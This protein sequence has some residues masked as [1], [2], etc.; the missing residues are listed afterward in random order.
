MVPVLLVAGA[1]VATVPHVLAAG[2]VAGIATDPLREQ[3]RRELLAHVRLALKKLP[4]IGR[5]LG[6]K[7]AAAL[8]KDINLLQ[9]NAGPGWHEWHESIA[10]VRLSR[11]M[12]WEHTKGTVNGTGILL[13]NTAAAFNALVDKKINNILDWF[14]KPSVPQGNP[15]GN[16]RT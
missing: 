4:E 14:G 16:I 5:P 13:Y 3:S 10:A 11:F 9:K 1:V 2:Y 7:K 15:D 12:G 8:R 6:D